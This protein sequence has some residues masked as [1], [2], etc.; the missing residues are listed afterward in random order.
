[1]RSIMEDYGK[2]V[3]NITYPD[4]IK[5]NVH[6]QAFY[7]VISA[8]LDDVLDLGSYAEL[9]SDIS[10]DI[11]TIIEKHS[12]IDWRENLEIHKHIAQD[13]DDLFYYYEKEKGLKLSFDVIDKIIEN[14]KT[15]ALRRF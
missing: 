6:A 8:I 12:M 15:V 4:K 2:G 5:N 11:T 7:G 9:L 3:T 13:I 1:M 10:I 14:V